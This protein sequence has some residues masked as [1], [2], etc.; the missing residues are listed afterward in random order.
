MFQSRLHSI[1]ASLHCRESRPR[2]GNLSNHET[3]I[4]RGLQVRA[5]N[6]SFSAKRENTSKARDAKMGRLDP[7]AD[8]VW[9]VRSQEQAMVLKP[10]H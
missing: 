1:M 2:S 4:D 9:D 10:I 6:T 8:E 7:I 5:T 3:E